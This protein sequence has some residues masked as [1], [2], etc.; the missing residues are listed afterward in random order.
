MSTKQ[1]GC[2]PELSTHV[3][4]PTPCAPKRPK[5]QNLKT[6]LKRE[7]TIFW[8]ASIG[9]RGSQMKMKNGLTMLATQLMKKLFS[10]CVR[11]WT[12]SCTAW[13][14]GTTEYFGWETEGAGWWEKKNSLVQKQEKKLEGILTSFGHQ[15]RLESNRMMETIHITDNFTRK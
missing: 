11:L 10:T 3:W 4:K 5:L 13:A 15:T 6:P 1:L 9:K 2:S 7:K 8:H 14:Y 12:R